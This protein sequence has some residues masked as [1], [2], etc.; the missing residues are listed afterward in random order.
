MSRMPEAET[1]VILPLAVPM[2]KGRADEANVKAD[3]ARAKRKDHDSPPRPSSL[4]SAISRGV[5]E[6]SAV[7]RFT[8]PALPQ[9]D[10]HAPAT[11]APLVIWPACDVTETVQACADAA[12]GILRQLSLGPTR[13]IALTSPDEGVG[14][15]GVLIALAP[16]LAR[17]TAKSVLVVDANFRKPDLT[18]RLTMPADNTV[19]RRALI[20]P[21]NLP[22][23]SVL[24]APA[25]HGSHSR[26]FDAS[27]SAELRQGWSLVLFDTPSLVCPETVSITRRC[28]GVYLVVRLG[29]TARRAVADSAR[30]IRASGGRLLGCVV[31]R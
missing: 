6:T 10:G 1:P 31:V 29:H 25:T 19:D 5:M 7:G 12:D 3:G 8:F 4:T 9:P 18:A 28:D 22:R 23:L 21:T 24:P 26:G 11:K 2:K 13:M 27:G 17:R 14:K 30:V 20:Y 16:E 15:T